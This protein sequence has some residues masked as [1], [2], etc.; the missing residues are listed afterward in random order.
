MYLECRNNFLD[1]NHELKKTF[2]HSTQT[3]MKLCHNFIDLT[4][5]R[6]ILKKGIAATTADTNGAIK[7][8]DRP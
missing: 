5:V 3:K 8:L 6:A 7:H 2:Y 1:A 4:E